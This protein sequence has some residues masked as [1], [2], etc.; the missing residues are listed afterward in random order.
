VLSA[1]PCRPRLPVSSLHE[2]P[3]APGSPRSRC[4]QTSQRTAVVRDSRAHAP[5][6]LYGWAV[7]PRGKPE[8]DALRVAAIVLGQGESSRL[9][10]LLVRDRATARSVRASTDGRRGA[11]LLS[12][13]ARLTEDARVGDVE[14]LIEGEIEALSTTGPSPAELARAQRLAQASSVAGIEGRG[15]RAKALGEHEIFFGDAAHLNGEPSRYLAV[16]RE[17]VQRA[18]KAHLGPTRRTI[19]ETYPVERAAPATAPRPA[20]AARPA[21]TKAAKRGAPGKGAAKAGHGAGT[22][23]AP[24]KKPTAMPKKR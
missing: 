13:D 19:V 1:G 20:R 15:A 9:H 18:V 16:T 5:A 23:T 2:G 11:A 12:I 6:I 10:R 21:G 7:P 3:S 22:R 14:K 8:H 4:E 24:R 17:D